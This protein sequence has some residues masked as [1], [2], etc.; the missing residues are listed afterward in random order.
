LEEL[1]L[2]Y[3]IASGHGWLGG[4]GFGSAA[5][6]LAG[7]D[8]SDRLGYRAASGVLTFAGVNEPLSD[9]PQR[10][11]WQS[12]IQGF[13]AAAHNSHYVTSAVMWRSY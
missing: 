5:L 10:A 2:R 13:A 7:R 8:K 12:G 3:L 4:F 11:M 1:Q 6:Q 9:S